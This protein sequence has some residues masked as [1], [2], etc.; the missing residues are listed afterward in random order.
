M[1]EHDPNIIFI[2]HDNGLTMVNTRS[3]EPRSDRYVLPSQC[4]RV[5]YS[6]VPERAGWS[7]VVKY[8]PRG[9]SIEYNVE[10]EDDN[11]QEDGDVEENLVD[12]VLD[13][14]DVE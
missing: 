1:S 5:F 3:F 10:E 8:D 9:R 12:L 13:H 4:E 7:Y 11:V 14:E 2:Q 6:E